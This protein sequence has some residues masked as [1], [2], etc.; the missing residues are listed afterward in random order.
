LRLG[1]IAV[2][3]FGSRTAF[4]DVN[5]PRASAALRSFN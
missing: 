5:F 4:P 3:L 2:F 1:S